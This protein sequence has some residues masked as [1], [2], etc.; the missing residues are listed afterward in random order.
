MST[1]YFSG[2]T[3]N[4]RGIFAFVLS[5]AFFSANDTIMKFII[6][7]YPIGEAIFARGLLAVLILAVAI[8]FLEQP[9]GLRQLVRPIILLRAGLD[10]LTSAGAVVALFGLG[11]AELSAIAQTSP[12][13]LTAMAA[14]F[15]KEQVRWRRW[16]AVFVGFSGTLFI[17]KPDGGSINAWALIALCVVCVAA[18]RDLIT[19]QISRTIPVLGIS[20]LGSA[21]LAGIGLVFVLWETWVFPSAQA[22]WL[23]LLAATCHASATYFLVLAFRGVT[24]S[25]VSPFRYTMLL[26]SGLGGYLVFHE[27]PRESFL[28]GASLIVGS[29]LYTLYRES[30][31]RRSLAGKIP[32]RPDV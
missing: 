12:L 31:V 9:S 21:G 29:G 15:Y 20:L 16:L 5:C 25:V 28:L 4:E 7:S 11:V 14:I 6:V 27:V 13:V 32:A 30:Q 26:W 2:F 23:I 1:S 3:A 24:V 17:I 10:A 18:T 22:C 8:G 19:R